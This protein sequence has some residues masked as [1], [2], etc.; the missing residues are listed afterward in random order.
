MLDF[1]FSETPP[2]CTGGANDGNFVLNLERLIRIK[3][4]NRHN[5]YSSKIPIILSQGE[6]FINKIIIRKSTL[7]FKKLMNNLLLIVTS[8]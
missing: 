1:K 5:N 4:N 2:V 8:R 6:L 7:F 3:I